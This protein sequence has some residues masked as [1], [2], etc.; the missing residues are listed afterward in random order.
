MESKK[1]IRKK[2][3]LKR[4]NNYYNI[5][6]KFF[7]PLAKIFKNRF[8]NK[9]INISL[10]YPSFY[11]LNVLKILNV[12]FFKKYKFLL[13][14]ISQSNTMNFFK[15]DKYDTLLINRYGIPEP[16]KSIPVI[17]DVVL[18]PL[19]AFDKN[20]NRLGYGKGYYDKYLKKYIKIHKNIVTVGIAFSFQRHHNLPV[21]N[22]DFKLHY[23]ITEKGILKWKY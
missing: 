5:D 6:E 22:S 2:F 23:V 8:K 1:S 16:V 12:N 11:E 17:P 20:K 9:K 19:L 4:K 13:P 21:S 14:K 18:L 10:Y 15:W 3:F 7:S